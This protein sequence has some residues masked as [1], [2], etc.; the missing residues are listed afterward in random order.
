MTGIL[1]YDI[2]PDA[3][4]VKLELHASDE[5]RGVLVTT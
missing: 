5:S 3:R 4:I 1:V 2:S